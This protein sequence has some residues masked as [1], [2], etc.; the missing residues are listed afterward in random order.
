MHSFLV[1][2]VVIVADYFTRL[3]LYG[4]VEI[5]THVFHLKSYI[6]TSP[7]LKT[8]SNPIC[9]LHV[10]LVVIHRVNAVSNFIQFR[11][12]FKPYP[13]EKENIFPLSFSIQALGVLAIC[14]HLVNIA[15]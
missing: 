4:L 12:K 11:P 2:R 7:Y 1:L 10:E 5:Q 9:L 14:L 8:Q 13:M 3:K 6:Q 15:Q